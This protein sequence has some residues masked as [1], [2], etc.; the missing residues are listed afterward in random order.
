L[1]LSKAIVLKLKK[2]KKLIPN[3]S[4]KFIIVL[5]LFTQLDHVQSQYVT[6]QNIYGG[7]GNEVIGDV[8]PVTDGVFILGS[9]N[10]SNGDFNVPVS[11]NRDAFI[12]KLNTAG[13]VVWKRTY[14]GSGNEDFEFIA[15][16][17]DGGLIAVGSASVADGDV[18]GSVFHGGVDDAWV[19]KMNAFGNIQWQQLYGGSDDDWAG[20]I[21]VT[22]YG[23]AVMSFSSSHDGQV[24][25]HHGGNNVDGWVMKLSPAGN[26]L[27]QNCYGGSKEEHPAGFITNPD[28]SFIIA[29][30]TASKNGN[31]VGNHGGLDGWIAKL[32]SSGNIMWSRC[33][34]G[35]NDEY[36]NP[37][38]RTSDGNIVIAMS[39]NSID[40]D[41]TGNHGAFDMWGV[42]INAQNGSIMWQKCIGNNLDQTAI[43]VF[44]TSNGELVFSGATGSAY[45]L[46]TWDLYIVRT[47]SDGT[48]IWTKTTGGSLEDHGV[49]GIE[50]NN[51]RLMIVCE[52]HSSD[53]DVLNSHGGSDI[54]C[55]Q[56]DDCGNREEN[57]LVDNSFS[58]I[59]VYPNPF[60]T[61][62][63]LS[64]FLE[65][66]EK[67]SVRIFDV[68]GK[69]VLN[70]ADRIFEAGK[71]EL[72][73]NGEDM[74]SG[75]YFLQIQTSE[76]LL[77]ERLIV[78]K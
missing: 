76:N 11:H 9:T 5:I 77:T 73:W 62:T 53:G 51:G 1:P 39:T 29:E 20:T 61:S 47:T 70:P 24:S 25:N 74:K 38:I 23:Y 34:G 18:N 63:V 46:S 28:G 69:L 32:D 2:M 33:L 57:Q 26:I 59:S 6:N 3:P 68:D 65:Q 14:G 21:C 56:V 36:L 66:K 60:S 13:N 44:E 58:S 55:V 78:T 67:V 45:D 16:T 10:S 12:I 54:W 4:L 37:F 15:K 50:L 42:K 48:P 30:G 27:W 7:S 64:F 71:N 72:T 35:S 75:I 43:R 49:G 40:G 8:V 52:A 17:P 19:V 41:V 31:I 22:N